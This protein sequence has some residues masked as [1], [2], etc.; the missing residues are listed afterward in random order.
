MSCRQGACAGSAVVARDHRHQF[1]EMQASSADLQS[2]IFAMR[3]L[4]ISLLL[5]FPLISG[6]ALAAS[7]TGTV[8][9]INI[10]TGT[11]RLSDGT[12]YY[13]PNRLTL[14]R[15]RQGDTVRIQYDR[16]AGTRVANDIVKTGRA[17]N[18]GPIIVPARGGGVTKNFSTNTHMCDPTPEDRN[19]CYDI[20]GQ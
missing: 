9:A 3:K 6:A 2:R 20:G 19:P 18:A 7:D 14:N 15:L 11:L 16:E 12:T 13:T 8:N 4:I 10:N 1:K 17:K 5:T